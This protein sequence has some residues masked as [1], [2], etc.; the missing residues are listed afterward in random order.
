MATR[1]FR[2]QESIDFERK[3]RD[4]VPEF[5]REIGCRAITDTRS[6]NSQIV[7]ATL[8]TGERVRMR[9]KLC[10]R[11]SRRGSR[12]TR[13]YSATQLLARI[14]DGDW[15]GS[16]QK[17]VDA[18]HARGITHYLLLQREDERITHA[19]LVPVDA[20]VPIWIKQRD[21][22]A[23]VIGKGALKRVL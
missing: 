2:T 19:A 3:T 16:I 1:S 5:L 9:V 7:E 4:R 23:Q 11:K 17:R 20:L 6:G 15:I 12:G 13:P 10:W 22:S 18:A 14:E 8:P 21:I